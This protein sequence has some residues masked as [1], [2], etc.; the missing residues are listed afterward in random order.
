MRLSEHV[1]SAVGTAT[2]SGD[3]VTI[4]RASWDSIVEILRRQVKRYERDG[5][6]GG[7]SRNKETLARVG[8][9]CTTY[10]P[11]ERELAGHLH[12][13]LSDKAIAQ[14]MGISTGTVK[15]MI[16]KCKDRY[17]GFQLRKA[18]GVI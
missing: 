9:D 7:R 6:K 2:A 10:S 14:R 12:E 16:R 4:P 13:G 1:A 8:M 5:A 17:A 18:R 15:V 11:R 3:Y